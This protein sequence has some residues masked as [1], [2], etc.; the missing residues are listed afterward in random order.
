MVFDN[1]LLHLRQY[2]QVDKQS[3]HY[4]VSCAV[5]ESIGQHATL[6]D[7]CIVLTRGAHTQQVG[8][9]IFTN[10]CGVGWAGLL[11]G[12]RHVAAVAVQLVA[13]YSEIKTLEPSL[14]VEG[15][16]GA[17]MHMWHAQP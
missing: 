4:V 3:V 15:V 16:D 5:V 13:L 8:Y 2:T 11:H 14:G 12:R 10:C 17:P 6:E 7:L 9:I 1:A